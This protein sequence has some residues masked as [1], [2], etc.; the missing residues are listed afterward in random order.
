[1]NP[2]LIFMG[3][4]AIAWASSIILLWNPPS[5][6]IGLAASIGCAAGFLLMAFS[7]AMMVFQPVGKPLFGI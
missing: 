2:I 5:N 4:V 1:M 3:G 6:R 7:L